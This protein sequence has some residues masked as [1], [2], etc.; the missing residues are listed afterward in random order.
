MSSCQLGCSHFIKEETEVHYISMINAV[1][2]HREHNA[3]FQ[4]SIHHDVWP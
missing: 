2:V 4:V 3:E 1:G